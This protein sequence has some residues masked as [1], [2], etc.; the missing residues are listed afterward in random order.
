M[1]SIRRFL[2]EGTVDLR[3]DFE[4]APEIQRLLLGRCPL[5]AYRRLLEGLRR[6][7]AVVELQA[8]ED[9]PDH[10][11]RMLRAKRSTWRLSHDIGILGGTVPLPTRQE[12]L[13][14]AGAIDS[15]SAKLGAQFAMA[16]VLEVLGRAQATIETSFGQ[17]LVSCLLFARAPGARFTSAVDQLID[18]A[19]PD[20]D[21]AEALAG[22][23]RTLRTIRQ[24]L[25]ERGATQGEPCSPAEPRYS[26]AS[27]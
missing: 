12:D 7:F 21:W 27:A 4:Y 16:H 1:P 13:D 24:G 8:F 17:A 25:V 23:R 6:G 3:R 18:Q 10:A 11:L 19:G 15:W 26:A 20:L 9:L 22:A 5:A 2:D 14:N